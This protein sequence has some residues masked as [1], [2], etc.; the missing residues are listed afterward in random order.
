[1]SRSFGSNAVI[2]RDGIT[3]M[4][5]CPGVTDT[6][7]FDVFPVIYKELSEGHLDNAIHQK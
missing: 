5:L 7:I 1:M 6:P 2:K 3:V 4:C